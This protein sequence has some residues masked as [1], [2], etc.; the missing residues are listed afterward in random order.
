MTVRADCLCEFDY[1]WDRSHWIP[2]CCF[3][4][5]VEGVYLGSCGYVELES[6]A[7][8]WSI[9]CRLAIVSNK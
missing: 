9:L 7:C 5:S 3:R 2:G 6:S 1:V 8:M 4:I